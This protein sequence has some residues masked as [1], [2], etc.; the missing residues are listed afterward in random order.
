MVTTG[1]NIRTM[2]RSPGRRRAG[3]RRIT[4]AYAQPPGSQ[5]V[6]AVEQSDL[7]LEFHSAGMEVHRGTV[8]QTLGRGQQ[9]EPAIDLACRPEQAGLR[10]HHPAREVRGFRARQVQRRALSRHGPLLVLA[11][12]LHAAYPQPPA[13][14][15]DLHLLLPVHGA[16]D[17]GAGYDGSESAQREGTVDGQAEG[18]GWRP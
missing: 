2:K 5:G 16:G 7:R 3:S 15:M 6:H 12:N 8:L 10:E 4:R 13:A 1:E 11:V 9:F 17:E 18:S 14:G